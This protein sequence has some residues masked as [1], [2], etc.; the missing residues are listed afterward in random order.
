[1]WNTFQHTLRST[2]TAISFSISVLLFQQQKIVLKKC[3]I[4]FIIDKLYELFV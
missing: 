1:M 2:T 4:F 3:L